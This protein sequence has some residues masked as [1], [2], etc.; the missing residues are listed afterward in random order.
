MVKIFCV[1]ASVYV[2]AENM[3]GTYVSGLIGA[4]GTGRSN[5]ERICAN[6]RVRKN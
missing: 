6:E 4:L 2:K 1:N 5:E 3:N